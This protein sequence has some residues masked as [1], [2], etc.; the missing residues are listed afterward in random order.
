ME[1]NDELAMLVGTLVTTAKTLLKNQRGEFFPF[2]AIINADGKVEMVGAD[3]GVDQPKSSDMIDFLR[4]AL[5]SM[6]QQGRIKG[7]GICVNVGARLPG[8]DDKVDAICLFIARA[9]EPSID[10]YVPF[11]KGLLGYKYDKPV[12]LP[13]TMNIF[14]SPAS[15]EGKQQ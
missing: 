6:A 10:L 9:A 12:V 14:P 4:G 3:T 5:H 7:S 1:A 11:R 15:P 8:Y 2:A 13:G